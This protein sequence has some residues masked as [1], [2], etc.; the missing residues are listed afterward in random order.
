LSIFIVLDHGFASSDKEY[1]KSSKFA[2]KDWSLALRRSRQ[3]PK[4]RYRLPVLLPLARVH[5]QASATQS[6]CEQD[7][8]YSKLAL[9]ASANREAKL[10]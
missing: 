7:Q 9:T 10:A 5:R 4:L 2:S 8:H 6:I 3:L 1:V